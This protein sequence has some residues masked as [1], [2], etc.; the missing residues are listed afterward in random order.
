MLLALLES[1]RPRQWPKNIFVFP[2]LFFDG[3]LIHFPS[4]IRTIVAFFLLCAMSSAVYLMNDL[5]DIDSDRKHPTKKNRPLPS[6]RLNP[7]IALIASVL[8]ALASLAGGYLIAPSLAV[9]LLIYLLIQ[10]AYTFRL[11]HIVLLDVLAVASGFILRVAA[12]VTAIDVQRFSPWIYVCAGLL[13]LFMVL[14]RRRHEL[15]LL[16]TSAGHHR[17][18]LKEYSVELIDRLISIVT[19]SAIVAYCLYTFLSEGVPGNHAMMLTIPIVVYA[20]FRYLYLIHIRQEGGA[21]EEIVLR[22]RPLQL[23]VI[24]YGIV[25]FI[26]LYILPSMGAG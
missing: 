5:A 21:P 24:I 25:A 16:G 18:I 13:S 8:L 23:T 17:A 2:A 19:S 4:V 20:I 12:G 14:G 15:I 1:M 6:G 7:Q 3:K 11:K 22:D 10:I 26:A 9:V